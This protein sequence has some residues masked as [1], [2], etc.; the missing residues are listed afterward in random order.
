M[1]QRDRQPE[2]A[3]NST[4]NRFFQDEG[5]V[6]LTDTFVEMPFLDGTAPFIAH[7]ITFAHDDT[8]A[9]NI[10]EYS[11]DGTTVHGKVKPEETFS[12]GKDTVDSV[13]LRF[14][15]GGAAFDYRLWAK[16]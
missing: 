1:G 7:T 12:E 15:A 6:A 14:A 9:T 11:F 4:K 2:R 5:D 13:W 10:L 16:G 8:T 3:A